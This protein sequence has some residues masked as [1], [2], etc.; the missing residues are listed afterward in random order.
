MTDRHAI[1]CD[2]LRLE[3]IAAAAAAD[4]AQGVAAAERVLAD[5]PDDARLHFLRGSLLIGLRRFIEAHAALAHAVSLA[6]DFHVARFQLGFF[7]LTSGE[8]DAARA[9]WAPLAQALEPDHYL[10]R[11]VAGL[12]ALIADDFAGCIASLRMGIAA[13]GENLPLNGDMAL[14]VEKCQEL[15]AQRPHA[16]RQEGEAVSATSFMLGTRRERQ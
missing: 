5:Y 14:I 16:A 13:N 4:S 15:V 11:F 1:L 2:E 7:E 12:T 8:A 10:S 9:T 3:E 6:P